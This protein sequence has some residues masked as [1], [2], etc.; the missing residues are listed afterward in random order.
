MLL[1]WYLNLK[2]YVERKRRELKTSH[3]HNLEQRLTQV[4]EQMSLLQSSQTH[5][6]E[7]HLQP[8]LTAAAKPTK[9]STYHPTQEMFSNGKSFGTYLKLLFIKTKVCQHR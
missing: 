6:G 8:P 1:T 3:T 9:K 7:F 5:F 4:Q 2:C